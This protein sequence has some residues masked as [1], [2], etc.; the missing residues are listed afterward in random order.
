MLVKVGVRC[1]HWFRDL[2]DTAGMHFNLTMLLQVFSNVKKDEA[3]L[4][5]VLGIIDIYS[6]EEFER[7]R[8]LEEIDCASL[9]EL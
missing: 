5:D 1:F 3:T 8:R 4:L 2:L 9:S 7:V 6:H